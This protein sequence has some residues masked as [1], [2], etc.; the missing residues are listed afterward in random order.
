[1]ERPLSL[2]RFLFYLDVTL[3]TQLL[4]SVALLLLLLVAPLASIA[5]VAAQYNPFLLFSDPTYFSLKPQGE[6]L[7]TVKTNFR[8][9]EVTIVRLVGASYG[10]IANSLIVAA[11]VTSLASLLGVL[12]A[13]VMARYTFPG[14]SALRI[15][16]TV[17]LLQTPFI[18]SFVIKKLFDWRDGLISWLISDVLGA[19]VR[20]G[21]EGLAAVAAAQVMSFFPIVYLNVY[22]SMVGIDPS[23]E[24]QAENL[25]AKGFKLFRTVTLPL[26]LP[27]LAAGAALVF[28]FSLEDVGAPIVFNEQRLMSYQIFTRFVEATTGRLSPAAA[29][30]ALLLLALALTVFAGIR[31]YVSLKQYAMLSRG[32][33][34]KPRTRKLGSLG[35]A[36]VY[37]GLLPL[38]LFL[39]FPQIAVFAYAFAERWTGALPE[40][41]TLRHLSSI[42]ADPLVS[43]AVYNSLVYSTA[44]LAL[45]VLLGVSAPYVIA[46]AR[47][48]GLEILDLLVTSPVAIP[49]LA[50]AVGYF[51]FFSTFFR[52]TPLDPISAGPSLLLILAYSVRRLP[53]TARAVFAG[54]QQVHVALE[55]AS[56]NLGAGRL[57]TLASVV[58]PLIGLSALS[59]ALVS[60][61]Y[62]I[63]ETSTSV[64]LGGLGGVGEGHRAPITFIMMDYLSRIGG[65]HIVAALGVLL[66]TL[67][68][69]AI[70]TV[71]VVLKQRYA[72]IGV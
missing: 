15:L 41:F 64:T 33:R 34:W 9:R 28:I 42:V 52:G 40:G 43:R 49:G 31:R 13:F 21:L 72:Y 63:G 32:G 46:R 60:F 19:P 65:P 62:C 35:L 25:G 67:Q 55:E 7:F 69:T 17:P 5:Y 37:L 8:G 29:S 26:S 23:L 27:G 38:L 20:V 36:V 53:F 48:R 4:L 50:V 56:M 61:V 24:E 57:R 71:N 6:F 2:R 44:A 68:L 22:A 3:L 39:A 70:V 30:L 18:N 59:G 12:V 54:L 51:Y 14:R 1:M 47:M 45:I 16:A 10:V 58:L 66:I 11:V